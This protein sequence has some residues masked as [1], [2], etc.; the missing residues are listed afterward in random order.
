[1]IFSSVALPGC[2]HHS[3]GVDN[4]RSFSDA[5]NIDGLAW[6]LHG[7]FREYI[8]RM[9]DG[10]MTALGA[11]KILESGEAYFPI[12]GDNTSADTLCFTGVFQCTGH[13]GML[14]VTIQ[15]P[16]LQSADEMTTLTIVDPFDQSVRMDLVATAFQD[17]NTA[18][19]WL[20]EA[21]TD[22][23]MGNY[24]ENMAFDPLRIIPAGKD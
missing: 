24:P 19:T 8:A 23:F 10:T 22:V 3:S 11:A 4:M 14:A 17:D 6:G 2:T 1:M 20:T 9:S 16:W 15:D 5:A 12:D 13:H 18:R 21:G 7:P